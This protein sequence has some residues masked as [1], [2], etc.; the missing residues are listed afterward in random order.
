MNKN[1]PYCIP[2][3]LANPH[4]TLSV[5][6]ASPLG[7]WWTK[8]PITFK[9]IY[10]S[11]WPKSSPASCSFA[12]SSCQCLSYFHKVLWWNVFLES[13]NSLSL[14]NGFAHAGGFHSCFTALSLDNV[15]WPL[16]HITPLSRYYWLVN[17]L[18][19]S[20]TCHFSYCLIILLFLSFCGYF[21]DDKKKILQCP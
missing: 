15:S 21:G 13:F 17:T 12:W 6:L 5:S 10:T 8:K 16:G 9:D 7:I 14:F 3:F 1:S 18:L 4:P 2:Q 11:L 20:Y 19:F